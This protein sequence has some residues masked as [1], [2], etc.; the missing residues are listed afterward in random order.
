[1]STPAPAIDTLES[2]GAALRWGFETAAA[3]GARVITCADPDF[4][5]WPLDDP[6]LL[7]GLTDWIRLPQ[8]QLVLLAASY[9]GVPRQLPRFTSWRRN[10]SHAIQALKAPQEFASDVSTLLLDDVSVCVHLADRLNWRG[11]AA[12]DGRKRWLWQERIDV[13]LQRSEPGFT[14]STLGL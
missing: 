2:F 3:Q 7:Q 5:G 1:M 8:R 10:W 13:V 6:Q 4:E 14:I 11:L 12:A 9:D